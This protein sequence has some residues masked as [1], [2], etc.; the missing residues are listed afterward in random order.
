VRV[1]FPPRRAKVGVERIRDDATGG[2]RQVVPGGAAGT[3]DA[4]EDWRNAITFETVRAALGNDKFMAAGKVLTTTGDGRGLKIGERV[5]VAWKNGEPVVIISHH[6]QG[7]E[8]TVL[9]PLKAGIVE[10]LFVAQNSKGEADV[11]FRNVEQIT[12]LNVKKHTGGVEPDFVLWGTNDDAFVVRDKGS[13]TRFH[14]FRLNR[15]L[16]A[17]GTSAHKVYGGR[18]AKIKEKLYTVDLNDHTYPLTDVHFV[19]HWRAGGLTS[20]GTPTSSTTTCTRSGTSAST[21]RRTS[22]SG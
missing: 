1:V 19:Y 14:V 8:F 5:P 11:Y 22:C 21:S 20:R 9:G 3:A 13:Q 4:G 6:V 10:E 7:G 17:G 2:A 15:Q 18:K 16:G 12:A